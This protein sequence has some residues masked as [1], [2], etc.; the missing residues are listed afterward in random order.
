MGGRS[1][2][3]EPLKDSV[4]QGTVLG[5]PLWNV[6]YGDARK[7]VTQLG[8][9][10][11]IF[12]DDFNCWKSFRRRLMP[13]QVKAELELRGAQR[14]LHLWGRANR[15]V[16]DPAKES[17]HLL[18]K[19]LHLGDDFR[20]LGVLFDPQLLMHSA[21]RAVATEAGWRIQKLLR[22]RRYYTTPE[23]MH[24]YKAQVLSYIES[25]TPGLYHAAPSVLDKVDRVQRRLLRELNLDEVEGLLDFR[26]A[27][28]PSRRD[29]SMLGTL[30]KMT[31]GI[32][33]PQLAAL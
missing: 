6:F 9:T 23:L 25:A 14:E 12:A 2:G 7:A 4:F 26:L 10:E 29:M 11:T 24:L 32:A 13:A 5:S 16:F 33:P 31:L 20:I 19:T 17:F 22:A 27:P 8:F 1:A 21:T 15:V 3:C 30:H 18:H 28:L